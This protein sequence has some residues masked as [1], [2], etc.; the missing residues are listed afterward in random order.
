MGARSG[1]AFGGGTGIPDRD[2]PWAGCHASRPCGFCR[3]RQ[4]PYGTS[5]RAPV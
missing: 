4:P 2:W 3:P 5:T 1:G